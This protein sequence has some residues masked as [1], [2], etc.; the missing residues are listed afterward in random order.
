VNATLI[1]SALLMGLAGSAH[2]VAMC[3]ATSMAVVRSCASRGAAPAQMGFHLG[4]FIGYVALGA[5]VASSV[6]AMSTWSQASPVLR[7]FWTMAHVAALALGVYLLVRGVQPEWMA[8]LGKPVSTAGHE[9]LPGGWQR[10]KGP[11]RSTAAGSIWWLWPCGLLQSALVVAALAD[12]AAGGAAVMAAFAIASSI[13]LSLG[14]ALWW[15]LSAA[16]KGGDPNRTVTWATRLSG[17]F[18]VAGSAFAMAHGLWPTVA[19]WCGL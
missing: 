10:M 13:G 7:P 14:P 8:R 1:L 15:K 16:F 2:C 5:V 19:A 9:P 17:A 6:S 4:R 12:G 18:L 11:V 3:G